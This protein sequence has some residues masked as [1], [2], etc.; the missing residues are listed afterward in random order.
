MLSVKM[1]QT[2]ATSWNQTES[3]VDAAEK[4]V[5][6]G[7]ESNHRSHTIA[8]ERVRTIEQVIPD[9][10]AKEGASSQR[11]AFPGVQRRE[12]EGQQRIEE[13]CSKNYRQEAAVQ[14][15]QD[16]R[17]LETA[18]LGSPT[19]SCCGDQECRGEVILGGESQV[20][21]HHGA[22]GTLRPRQRKWL[23]APHQWKW[24]LMEILP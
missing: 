13:L 16:T 10:H 23:M 12:W 2:E 1:H 11:G 5:S 6:N 21:E 17:F 7:Q 24:P 8:R 9:L 14:L 20:G 22:P 15:Q 18:Q 3:G 4:F 19:M